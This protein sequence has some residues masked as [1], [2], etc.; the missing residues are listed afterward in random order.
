[1]Y[2]ADVQGLNAAGAMRFRRAVA[3]TIELH[4]NTVMDTKLS[5]ANGSDAGH[6]GRVERRARTFAHQCG[7]NACLLP[8]F[9]LPGWRSDVAY[10]HDQSAAI[11][12]NFANLIGSELPTLHVQSFRNPHPVYNA[13][14]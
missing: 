13:V 5:A 7:A 6:H 1:M 14:H 9:S 11:H 3:V 4:R 10:V 2:F 12:A 8:V